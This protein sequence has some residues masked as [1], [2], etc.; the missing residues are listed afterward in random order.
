MSSNQFSYPGAL[1][2][3]QDCLATAVLELRAD[4]KRKQIFDDLT[5]IVDRHC[6]AASTTCRI[7]QGKIKWRGPAHVFQRRGRA[8]TEEAAGTGGI[9]RSGR[10]V[11]GGSGIFN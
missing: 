10:S 6:G 7:L 5:L 4:P 2:A 1:G 8:R 3:I 9:A 11:A